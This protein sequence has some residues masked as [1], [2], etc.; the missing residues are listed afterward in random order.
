MQPNSGMRFPTPNL[1][2][3]DYAGMRVALCQIETERWDLDGNFKRTLAAL[4]AANEKGADL[5]VTPECVIHG[6]AEA[7]S[8]ND[9]A[10]LSEVAETI[11][12]PRLRKIRETCARLKLHCVLG[13]AELGADQKIYNSAAF[14]DDQG[15]LRFIYRKVHCRPAESIEHEGLFTSGSE[16]YVT[17]IKV[18]AHTYKLG[19]MICFDREIPETT[20]CLRALGAELVLC[21][22]AADTNR[23]DQLPA[24][25][26]DNELITRVRAA[27]NEQFIVVVNHAK[28]FNGGSYI[29]GPA[30]EVI[31]QMG[32]EPG[33]EVVTL[34]LEIIAK[35]FHQN[36]LG[37]MGWG[38]RRDEVYD[39]YLKP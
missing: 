28:R 31:T 15:E 10:R 3:E 27:E 30:G 17:P 13:F 32:S 16:F 34:P 33:V 26:A 29:I 14:I 4:R 19:T 9:Q 20:R 24:D 23:W 37:W 1:H 12:G 39:K 35:R 18:G 5:A 22:L 25:Q 2:D 7:N 6:Y 38:Y 11:D 21:P 8:A 36:P